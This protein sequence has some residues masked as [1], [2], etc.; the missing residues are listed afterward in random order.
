V[1]DGYHV[2]RPSTYGNWLVFRS[3]LVD[4]SPA[5]GVEAVKTHLKLYPLSAASNPPKMKFVNPSGKPFNFVAP[6]EY[7]FWS[8]LNEVI[9]EEPSAAAIPPPWASSPPSASRRASLS[10]PTHG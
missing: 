4:G 7:S 1:P 9:Q 5:P 6:G 10:R 3:F 8:L 2:V